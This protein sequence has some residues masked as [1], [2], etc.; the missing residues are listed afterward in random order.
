MTPPHLTA[1]HNDLVSVSVDVSTLNG[2]FHCTF[3]EAFL[4]A[5]WRDAHAYCEIRLGTD[6]MFNHLELMRRS[7]EIA[8]AG[9]T[10]SINID[11]LSAATTYF[12]NISVI[13][14]DRTTPVVVIQG[15]ITTPISELRMQVKSYH[16][17][18][19]PRLCNH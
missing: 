13:L 19:S 2:R 11:D 1:A 10:A 15:V 16:Y 7:Q 4:I 3:L 9:E 5:F 14:E 18:V 17:S 8:S 6:P 12:Y